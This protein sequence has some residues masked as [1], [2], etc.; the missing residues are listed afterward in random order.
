MVDS[1]LFTESDILAA[2]GLLFATDI[3]NCRQMLVSIQES[4]VKKAYRQKALLTHPDRFAAFGEDLRKLR[5]E[6]FIE[7]TNAYEV[8]NTYLKT[9]KNRLFSVGQRETKPEE[10]PERNG[11][12]PRYRR[13]SAAQSH[14]FSGNFY[15]TS[16]FWQKDVP[17]RYLRLAEFLY[18]S[19][20]YYLE[21]ICQGFGVAE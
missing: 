5:S 7:V 9:S 3:D 12:N 21:G 15:T 18:Y 1:I 4:D 19:G 13:Q 6:Q 8:L 10:S 14:P 20:D 17:G 11:Q 2:L 16:S